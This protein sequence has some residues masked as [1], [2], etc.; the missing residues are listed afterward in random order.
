MKLPEPF[1]ITRITRSGLTFESDDVSLVD[2]RRSSKYLDPVSPFP[3]IIFF[4]DCKLSLPVVRY[5]LV[6]QSLASVGLL[7]SPDAEI[8]FLVY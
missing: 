3:I 8:L 6:D 2:S 5:H 7:N 4:A 1:I